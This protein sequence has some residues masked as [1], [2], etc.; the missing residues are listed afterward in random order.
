MPDQSGNSH[1]TASHFEIE[2]ELRRMNEDW[3]KALVGR[4]AATLERI[5]A[6]DCIFTYPLEGDDK[7]QFI[8]D[9]V[10]GDLQIEHF[11]REHVNVRIYGSTAVMSCLDTTSWKYHGR[12]ITG[13]Y[14]TLHIYAER[15]G[16]WQLVTVQSCP[17]THP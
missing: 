2:Q 9:V 14:R 1:S 10:A 5:M 6:D 13:Q 8:S 16:H 12:D 17:I 11:E 7:A 4:D 15:H 3:V